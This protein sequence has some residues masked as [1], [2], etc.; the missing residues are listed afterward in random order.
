MP[1]TGTIEQ[2]GS[3]IEKLKATGTDHVIFGHIFSSIGKDTR[4]M[5]EVTKQFAK[6]A[7]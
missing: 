7:K 5:V 6:F 4:K 2:V 1:M 3:D